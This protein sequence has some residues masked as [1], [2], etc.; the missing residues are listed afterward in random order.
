MS[1]ASLN[2]I[3]VVFRFIIVVKMICLS[4][5]ETAL[6]IELNELEKYQSW[7]SGREKSLI[8]NLIRNCWYFDAVP[9]SFA[10]FRP[11]FA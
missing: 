6:R 4:M 2:F 7:F 5:G 1:A 11:D 10:G 8:S 3:E 9:K